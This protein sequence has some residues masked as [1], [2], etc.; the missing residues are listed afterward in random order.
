M[1]PSL[2]EIYHRQIPGD[3][4]GYDACKPIIKNEAKMMTAPILNLDEILI[5]N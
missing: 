2:C 5:L 4:F 3:N 1:G